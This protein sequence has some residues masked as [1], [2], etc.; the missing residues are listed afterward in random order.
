MTD[1]I[2]AQQLLN[3]AKVVEKQVDAE[4]ERLENLDDDGLEEIRRNRIAQMKSNARK[5]QVSILYNLMLFYKV[6]L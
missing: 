2:I 4:I 3:A 1:Q 6:N 5:R